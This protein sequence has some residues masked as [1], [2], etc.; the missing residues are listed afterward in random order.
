[1][2]V[3]KATFEVANGINFF[4]EKIGIFEL[5]LYWLFCRNSTPELLKG[6]CVNNS[7]NAT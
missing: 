2:K 6:I 3:M 1:M 4:T 5:G 7:G